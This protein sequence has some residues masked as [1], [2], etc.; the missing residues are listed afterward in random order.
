MRF[1]MA[2]QSPC[3]SSFALFHFALLPVQLHSTALE[4]K[5][6]FL[7]GETGALFVGSRGLAEGRRCP[8]AR[9]QPLSRVCV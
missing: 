2:P 1:I 5:S 3:W 6:N 7:F 4:Q 8:C 9:G